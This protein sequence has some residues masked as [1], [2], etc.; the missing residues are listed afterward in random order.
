MVVELVVTGCGATVVTGTHW[1]PELV[2]V[3]DDVV[4]VGCEVVVTGCGA[5]VVTGTHW[6][7]DVVA[8]LVVG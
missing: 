5:T 2:V 7:P 4:V 3:V 6:L 1:F 8:E